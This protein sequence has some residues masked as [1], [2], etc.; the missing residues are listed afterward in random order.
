M[1]CG[2]CGPNPKGC[3]GRCQ[4]VKEMA[5]TKSKAGKGCEGCRAGGLAAI[6]INERWATGHSYYAKSVGGPSSILLAGEDCCC[7][8]M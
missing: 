6:F 4:K 3:G 5:E 2:R 8:L 7:S 1:L